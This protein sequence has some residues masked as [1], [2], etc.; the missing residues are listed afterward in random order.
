MEGEV[1]LQ[2]SLGRRDRAIALLDG[3]GRSPREVWEL[4]TVEAE[5]LAHWEDALASGQPSLALRGIREMLGRGLSPPLLWWMAKS[6]EGRALLDLGSYDEALMWMDPAILRTRRNQFWWYD[7]LLTLAWVHH[8]RGE[9]HEVRRAVVPRLLLCPLPGFGPWFV[10]QG[11]YLLGLSTR[12]PQRRLQHFA[13][14]QEALERA[15]RYAVYPSPWKGEN[16]LFASV[17]AFEASGRASVR[18][19][20]EA[21]DG[22][23]GPEWE[24]AAYDPLRDA[25]EH[26]LARAEGREAPN[27][28]SSYPRRYL[29]NWEPL[30]GSARAADEPD[31]LPGP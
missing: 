3:E 31:D 1:R 20:K 14:A 13:G 26:Q 16:L 25:L 18:P 4:G 30:P 17:A 23:S 2:L 28:L 7:A 29:A 10:G 24:G 8:F 12:D 21:L 6:L 19:L 27:P 5:S 11:S 15:E 22:L 9:H